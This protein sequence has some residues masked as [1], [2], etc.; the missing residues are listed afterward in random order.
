[1]SLHYFVKEK[2]SVSVMKSSMHMASTPC[3]ACLST[4]ECMWTHC[5]DRWNIHL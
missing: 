1:M 5:F 3:Y 2:N 4:I